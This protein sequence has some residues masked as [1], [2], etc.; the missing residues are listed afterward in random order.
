MGNLIYQGYDNGFDSVDNVNSFITGFMENLLGLDTSILSLTADVGQHQWGT[1]TVLPSASTSTPFAWNIVKFSDALGPDIYF[2][3]EW[4]RYSTSTS[5]PV[6]IAVSM[7]LGSDGNGNLTDIFLS[8]TMMGGDN[9]Y[10]N[11][12]Y[13]R[14]VCKDGILMIYMKYCTS[15]NSL[16]SE[17]G[18]VWGFSRPTKIDNTISQDKLL[19][20]R[21]QNPSATFVY[22]SDN[23]TITRDVYNL[24]TKSLDSSVT[25]NDFLRGQTIY[26]N[27]LKNKNGEIPYTKMMIKASDEYL[28][29][30]NIIMGKNN[31]SWENFIK[32]D[33]G[34][35][36]SEWWSFD[37]TTGTGGLDSGFL[38]AYVRWE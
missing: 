15:P 31:R 35:I 20:Y 27:N 25:V 9:S 38:G 6:L 10:S 4:V 19:L 11:P 21:M 33:D 28:I 2:K 26:Y 16:S 14:M 17:N 1:L 5:Y 7:G 37:S 23:T 36:F 30:P 8:R 12:Y 13:M 34:K 3:I 29:E 24:T 32:T 18:Y 22:F